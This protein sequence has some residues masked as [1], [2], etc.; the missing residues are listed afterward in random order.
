[1]IGR[2]MLTCDIDER[3]NGPPPRCEVIECDPL[4]PLYNG[5]LIALNG[6]FYGAKVEAVCNRGYVPDGPTTIFCTE[7]GQ[8]SDA[9]PRCIKDV[10]DETVAPTIA[11]TTQQ[12]TTVP[13]TTTQ[14]P[15]TRRQQS[16]RPTTRITTRISTTYPTTPA[17][18]ISF[19][20]EE[21]KTNLINFLN[22]H[23]E[24]YIF[25][26]HRFHS[27]RTCARGPTNQEDNQTSNYHTKDK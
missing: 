21:G 3:W 7:S 5:N 13:T 4:P 26:F 11:I 10:E 8:W 9:L 20:T 25:I 27:A 6:T 14:A 18:A 1:M 15:T 17:S 24:I 2:A 19:E 16:R 23:F 12:P 22:R